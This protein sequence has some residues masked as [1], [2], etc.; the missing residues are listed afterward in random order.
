MKKEEVISSFIMCIVSGLVLI[1]FTIAWYSNT[2]M[3]AVTGIELQAVEIGH[4]KV[5]LKSGGEDISEL[6]GDAKYADM[7]MAVYTGLYTD[8][9]LKEMAPGAYGQVT[10]YVTPTNSGVRTCS[11]VPELKITQDGSTWYPA[12]SEDGEDGAGSDSMGTG[13]DEEGSA[14]SNSTSTG[15]DEENSAGS[16]S[17][18]TGSDEENSAGNGSAGT[19]SDGEDSAGAGSTEMTIEKLYQIAGEHIHFFS[20]EEMTEEITVDNPLQLTWKP[21][22]WT[23]KEENGE[24]TATEKMAVI[25]WKW[26]YEYPL[27]EMEKELPVAEQKK[28]LRQYDE[29][30]MILGNFISNM[31]FYFT[32]AAQ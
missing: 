28:L 12:A 15:S 29:E 10:F 4:V 26:Y 22:D 7:G 32:F 2:N 19:G 18:G 11:I 23:V 25:Y 27:S 1:G 3:P 20:N 8:P 16:S 5:A 13:S 31:K 17:T 14:G 24:I 30:D 21:E 9:K 6:E